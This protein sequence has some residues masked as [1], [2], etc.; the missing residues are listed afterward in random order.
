MPNSEGDLLTESVIRAYIESVKSE[1]WFPVK[2]IRNYT[3]RI[4]DRIPSS[5]QREPIFFIVV[6][7]KTEG[8]RIIINLPTYSTKSNE[9]EGKIPEKYQLFS[10]LKHQVFLQFLKDIPLRQQVSG[11]RGSLI[12]EDFGTGNLSKNLGSAEKFRVMNAVQTNTSFVVDEKLIGKVFRTMVQRENLDIEIPREL[13]RYTN[14]RSTPT[15]LGQIYYSEE[16]GSRTPFISFH[17][18]VPNQGDYWGHF[19][20][21]ASLLK[22]ADS[23]KF[24]PRRL[25]DDLRKETQGISQVTSNLHNSLASIPLKRFRSENYEERDINSMIKGADH[26]TKDIEDAI[27]GQDSTARFVTGPNVE[28]IERSLGTISESFGR[29]S[30]KLLTKQKVHGDY[31][32]GQVLKTSRGPMVIDFE[33]EPLRSVSQRSEK[34]SPIKDVAGMTRSIDYALNF[35]FLSEGILDI[36]VQFS[37]L[38]EE[39]RT[40][41]L[42]TY[43]TNISKELMGFKGHGEFIDA[44]RVFELDKAV[45]ELDYELRNRPTWVAIPLNALERYLRISD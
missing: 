38:S 16:K 45:Y 20:E 3:A 23:G 10:A 31:H 24:E 35:P 21:V 5:I 7:I 4:I 32:L 34:A 15:P 17:E 28:R 22:G 44:V 8:R 13:Y 41:F 14:F 19:T 30:P 6:E 37:E 29:L 11:T 39:L 43:W 25:M 2:T 36:P 1:R 26:L 33:G 9:K 18:F 27:N 42:R 40:I 12:Y